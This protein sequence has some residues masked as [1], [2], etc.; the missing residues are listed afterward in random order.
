MEKEMHINAEEA[1]ASYPSRE[2]IDAWALALHKRSEAISVSGCVLEHSP[3]TESFG[4]S[5]NTL[6][7]RYIRF[8][9]GEGRCFYGYWQPAMKLPA[10]LLINLPGYGAYMTM[11]PQLC[12]DGYNILHISPLGYV[13][14]EGLDKS[15]RQP[16]GNLPVLVNTAKGLSGGYED[17]LTDCLLA[18]RWALSQPEAL[19]DRLSFFGMSQGGGA[20]LLLAS[21]LNDRTR[22]VC[23]DLP[24]LTGF[25]MTGLR[26]DAYG[27]LSETYTLTEKNGFWR[28]MGYF[29]TISHA[30]RLKMPVMLGAGGK[31]DVCPG[32]TV[33]ALFDKLPGTKQFTYLQNGV[34]THSRESMVLYRAWMG[35]F[36]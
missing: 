35:L 20:A 32:E 6:Q 8:T 31:D 11:H 4:N 2:D 9:T 34:H 19:P 16:D 10:P 1:F 33:K 22:C 14:A 29:D 30:H 13:T 23:A 25:P 36:A 24:F 5:A 12:D 18:V 17:W 21:I 27:M 3:I 28:R 15:R 7:N 26:G